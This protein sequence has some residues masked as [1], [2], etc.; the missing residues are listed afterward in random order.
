ML[1]RKRKKRERISILEGQHIRYRDK[2]GHFSRFRR[3]KDLSVWVYDQKGKLVRQL[4]SLSKLGKRIGSVDPL[5][6]IE[7]P[8]RPYE[9]MPKRAKK[10]WQP[11][12]R[13]MSEMY[14][15]D[16]ALADLRNVEMPMFVPPKVS[17]Y[18][19]LMRIRRFIPELEIYDDSPIYLFADD[20][21][22]LNKKIKNVW[23]NALVLYVYPDKRF[24]TKQNYHLQFRRKIP[25]RNLFKRYKRLEGELESIVAT[26]IGQREVG[27]EIINI[28]GISV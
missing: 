4:F 10:G 22:G 23:L 25:I 26:T 21:V 1:K 28:Q 14:L 19:K 3:N 9:Y 2:R 18:G 6:G 16:K 11:V 17:R 8:L 12:D 7:R 13:I 5:T 24:L 27:A 15:Q 20:P